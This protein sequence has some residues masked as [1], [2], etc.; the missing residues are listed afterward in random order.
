MQMVRNI[1]VYPARAPAHDRPQMSLQRLQAR[2][3]VA[4]DDN[5]VVHRDAK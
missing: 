2:V 5:V 3:A 1:R 4:A